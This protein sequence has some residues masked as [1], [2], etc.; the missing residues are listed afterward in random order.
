MPLCEIHNGFIKWNVYDRNFLKKSIYS[1]RYQRI[2]HAG[3]HKNSFQYS[4]FSYIVSSYKHIQ[5]SQMVYLDIIKTPEMGDFYFIKSFIHHIEQKHSFSANIR[6][7]VRLYEF[8]PIILAKGIYRMQLREKLAIYLS[9][10]SRNIF[11]KHKTEHGKEEKEN[12]KI[13]MF[14]SSGYFS[15]AA[16][17]NYIG[18]ASVGI[19]FLS[20]ENFLIVLSSTSTQY[21]F[22]PL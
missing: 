9:L 17:E 1:C 21:C 19:S 10:L 13:L 4:T 5:L 11:L 15:S 6:V 14:K 3:Q 12:L 20:L 2:A 8:T 16:T 22:F 7:S 18:L